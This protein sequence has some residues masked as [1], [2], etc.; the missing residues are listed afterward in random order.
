M[1]IV[2]SMMTVIVS[3][4]FLNDTSLPSIFGKNIG[5]VSV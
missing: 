3:V 4:F 1:F 5:S 2:G